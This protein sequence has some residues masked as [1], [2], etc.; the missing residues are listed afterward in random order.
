M[1]VFYL[2]ALQR[3]RAD[4]QTSLEQINDYLTTKLQ[5]KLSSQLFSDR[6]TALQQSHKKKLEAIASEAKVDPNGHYGTPYLSQQ[7]KKFCPNDTIWAIEAVTQTQFV[8]DQIQATLPGSWINCGGG[9]LGWSGGGALGIKLA[10][11]YEGKKKFVCQI[12]GDGTYLFTV[13]GSV[14]WISK[15]YNIPILTIV[16]NN[17]GWNAPKRS[18]LLVHPEGAGS[19]VSNEELN[20]SFAPTPDYSGIA[21]AASGGDIW[22][23]HASTADELNRLLPEAIKTVLDGKSAVLDAH[24]E[25]PEGK[26][27]GQEKK[28]VAM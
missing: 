2:N 1:P 7:L 24:L 23:A 12:V 9:G 16:L 26:F 15:R 20:I 19:K 4:S 25:G 3:Y 10:T 6:W 5:E 17:K 11:D 14:Y 22:A 18:L 27:G 21:K 13:P 8:A 28:A